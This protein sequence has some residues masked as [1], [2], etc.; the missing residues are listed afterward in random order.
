MQEGGSLGVVPSPTPISGNG[1]L[2]RSDQVIQHTSQATIRSDFQ[3]M[4]DD[5]QHVRARNVINPSMRG[6]IPAHPRP[7][8]CYLDGIQDSSLLP[9]GS[10]ISL[11]PRTRHDAASLFRA[12]PR[13]PFST[14]EW[15][16]SS[17]LQYSINRCC[18]IRSGRLVQCLMRSC[19]VTGHHGVNLA[20][21]R[22][23]ST[24]SSGSA[25]LQGNTH[26]AGNHVVQAN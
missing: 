15:T 13:N 25:V 22:R 19:P 18:P 6:S 2:P 9:P 12:I 21:A 5:R 17:R 16:S 24:F 20:P 4:F 10:M 8:A 7:I 23:S 1:L 26:Q 3:M 14:A 11:C